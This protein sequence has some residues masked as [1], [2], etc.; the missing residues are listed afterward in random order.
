MSIDSTQS[1][2]KDSVDLLFKFAFWLFVGSI[3]FSIAGMLLLKIFPST[4]AIFGPLYG[5]LVKTPT[6]TFMTM[7]AVLPILM[8]GTSLG[9][10]RMA[11]FIG[12]GCVIGGSSELMGTTGIFNWNGIA[13]PFGAYE[14]TEWLGPKMFEHVPYFIPPSWF[15]MGLVSFDLARRVTSSR[16]LAV[17][18]GTFFMVL[19]DVSLDPAMTQG[20]VQ[21]WFYEADGFYYGMPFSNWVGWFIVSLIIIAGYEYIGGGLPETNEWA[22]W[23]YILNCAFPLGILMLEGL[24]LAVFFG[25]LATALPFVVIRLAGNRANLLTPARA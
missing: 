14:Y 11:F 22:P 21:F 1:G 20:Q 8:Y 10:K 13:L 6:W 7:L 19:W 5:K 18:V 4:Y 15:A 16:G 9:W 12:W 3:S 2:F 23:L 24:Y 25:V 17:L